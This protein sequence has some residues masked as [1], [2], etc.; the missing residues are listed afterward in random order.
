M[1]SIIKFLRSSEIQNNLDSAIK[2]LNKSPNIEGQ[3]I[4]AFY[5][6]DEDK[7]LID[8][9]FCIGI[10]DGKGPD[11]YSVIS[12]SS[13]ILVSKVSTVESDI[14]EPDLINMQTAVYR[15][16]EVG[17]T[18]WTYIDNGERKLEEI[19][20]PDKYYLVKEST[21]GTLW[22]IGKDE[23]KKAHDFPTTAKFKALEDKTSKLSE[24]VD[25]L[26]L[27]MLVAEEKLDLLDEFVFPIELDVKIQE[28]ENTV[29]Q[30]GEIVD[31]QLSISVKKG[32]DNV[33]KDCNFKLLRSW[34]DEAIEEE[35]EINYENETAIIQCNKS[36][37]LTVFAVYNKNNEYKDNKSVSISFVEP[38]FSGKISYKKLEVLNGQAQFPWL[39]GLP[40][41]DEGVET[42]F[43]S[44]PNW[45]RA[46]ITNILK[47]EILETYEVSLSKSEMLL[48]KIESYT[49][50]G[51]HSLNDHMFFAYPEEFGELSSIEDPSY[52]GNILNSF[53]KYDQ[54]SLE[55]RG[56]EIPYYVYVKKQPAVNKNVV[57]KF[58]H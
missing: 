31:V 27:R 15:N 43:Y 40:L 13:T 51:E 34:D 19:E 58:N 56:K 17:K 48:D 44:G 36:E 25:G 46:A 53:R 30:K 33:T 2:K 3:P 54:V 26:L 16:E 14:T 4:V 47:G 7:T 55:I 57:F 35:I 52:G 11:T 21:T 22:W 38:S 12:S 24:T 8:C 9:I 1:N 20:D 42:S 5:Y 29:I 37:T 49:Y 41:L 18:Y 6:V 50:T 32:K 39:V 10:K 28:P 45:D 23:I